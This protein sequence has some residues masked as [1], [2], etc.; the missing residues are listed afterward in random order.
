MSNFA[1]D[2]KNALKL[3]YQHSTI[4]KNIT[5]RTPFLGHPCNWS[6]TRKKHTD[7]VF[8]NKHKPMETKTVWKPFNHHS[9]FYSNLSNQQWLL[10][11]GSEALW[12]QNF[13]LVLKEQFQYFQEV[14][15]SESYHVITGDLFASA[16]YVVWSQI[17][18]FGGKI[19]CI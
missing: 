8:T 9:R 14:A 4:S 7:L 2:K 3:L 5:T 18:Y 6:F 19:I 17:V 13:S 16:K 11:Y 10:L 1:T 15:F 12:E